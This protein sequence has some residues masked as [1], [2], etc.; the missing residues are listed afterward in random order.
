MFLWMQLSERRAGSPDSKCKGPEAGASD[1][2][3]DGRKEG[4]WSRVRSWVLVGHGQ[5]VG[6]YL[7]YDGDTSGL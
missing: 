5:V 6:S 2:R 1:R 7:R 4:D 3:R